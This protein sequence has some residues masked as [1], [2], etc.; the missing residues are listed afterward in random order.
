MSF[1]VQHRGS[2][3]Y[4][5]S[6]ALTGGA[7]HAFSTRLGGVSRGYLSSL[8]L[9]IHRGD[10]PA[11][12]LENYRI[13]G[14][15][16]GFSVHDTV[17][18]HQVHSDTVV[19]VGRQDRGMGLFLPVQEA[20]DGLVTN[21]PGVALVVFSAD[22]TPICSTIRSQV[23]SARYMPAGAERRWESPRAPWNG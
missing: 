8:N 7:E 22:C 5:T 23:R 20:R 10:V 21:E 11:R 16:V 6:D 14:A 1:S 4:L 15:A 18:T 13:L 17:F 3:E 12:V 19:R 9:G 2:L